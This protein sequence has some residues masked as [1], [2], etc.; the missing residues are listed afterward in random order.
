MK[1]GS[2]AAG[3]GLLT[4]AV[5]ATVLACSGSTTSGSGSGFPFSG[6]SC[7]GSTYANSCWGCAQANCAPGCVTNDC[8]DYYSCFCP[9]AQGDTTC[10][11][12]CTQKVSPA[13]QTCLNDIGACLTQSCQSACGL[14]SSSGSGGGSGGSSSGSGGG[15]TASVY[16]DV[17]TSGVHECFEYLNLSQ[18][19]A[20]T[21]E[22][23]CTV[24]LGGS[25]VTGCSSAGQVGCCAIRLSGATVSDVC[26]YCG[27]PS[28]YA[29]ACTKLSGAVWTAGSGSPTNCD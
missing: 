19:Q 2:R 29:S 15:G 26:Y 1:L 9:C 13:C 21:V 23:N 16:C 10:Y 14:G 24:S 27:D 22:R 5:L 11:S 20:T 17:T 4:G 18:A 6:P 28:T 12:G 7:S 3:I 8:S 25:I